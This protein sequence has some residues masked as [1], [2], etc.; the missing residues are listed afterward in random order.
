M[1]FSHEHANAV[2]QVI[3]MRAKPNSLLRFLCTLAFALIFLF[4]TTSQAQRL[5]APLNRND[6]TLRAILTEIEADAER[7]RVNAK[8]PGMSIVIV[9]DQ[10]VLLAKGFGYADLEKQ[11]S[12]DPQTVYRTGSVTKVF[13]ALMLMQLRDA[14]KLHLDDPIEKYLPEFKIKSRFPDAR[15]ATFRQV[16]AHYSGLP[17]E[18]P[19]LYEYQAT[20]EF[21]SVEDQLKSLEHSE[22]MLPAMTMYSYSNLGYNIMGLALSRVAEQSYDE[23]VVARIL[24]PLGMNSSGFALTEQLKK[25]FAV[26][27][28]PAGSD[29]THERSSYPR[30]GLASGMLYSNVNDLAS[31]LS[32]FFREGPRGGKQ[33]L[34]SSSLHE[35]LIP[36]AVSKD[37]GR[38]FWTA[39]S[40][41]GFSVN[42][43]PDGE[44]I[45]YKDGGTAGF[46]SIVYINP[47]RKLGMALL[48]NTE[49]APFALGYNLLRKLT[50]VLVKS[51]E[52]SQSKALEEVQPKWQKFIG[53]Y[54]ITDPSAIDTITFNEFNVRLVNQRLVLTVPEVRPGSVVWMKE[55]PLEPFGDNEFK[56]AGGSFGNKFITFEPGN[57]GSMRLKWRTYVF[58]RQP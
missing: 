52:R 3:T 10:D 32:L 39:G 45:A 48:T 42:P 41:I 1:P 14:G 29:G 46:S 26:G 18:A 30:H 2:E 5:A 40:T 51:L 15:P 34:G 6:S 13:T 35:M 58:K 33:V 24:K 20:D 23:Y 55:V 9:Y 25:Q 22:M 31:F 16:A 11:I 47:Q 49:T 38:F 37:E 21:P 44:Q 56:A 19:M 28:K 57:D 7:A 12:A 8:I 54:V 27:Y 17:R 53:R 43:F 4:H 36:V 50:P